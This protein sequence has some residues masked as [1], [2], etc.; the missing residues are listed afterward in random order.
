M[1]AKVLRADSKPG[2]ERPPLLRNHS[3]TTA[4]F[5]S[6]RAGGALCA[7]EMTASNPRNMADVSRIP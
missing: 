4:T 7:A 6:A 2:H 5:G 1:I 3:S